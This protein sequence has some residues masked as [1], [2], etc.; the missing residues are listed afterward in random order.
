[1]E[2][3]TVEKEI[4]ELAAFHVLEDKIKLPLAFEY[5]VD[6]YNV[7]VIHK[8]HHDNFP[9][10]TEPF[11]FES[12]LLSGDGSARAGHWMKRDNFDGGELSSTAV[13]CYADATICTFTDALADNPLADITG[14]L[15][16]F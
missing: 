8:L 15:R 14:V 6:T 10:D 16:K 13:F 7:W 1:M 5:I 2:P 11:L 12:G 4:K 3:S 9:V